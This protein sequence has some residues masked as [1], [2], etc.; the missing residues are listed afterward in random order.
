MEGRTD[1]LDYI[2]ENSTSVYRINGRKFLKE[3]VAT[4]IF[5]EDE[6]LMRMIRNV[7]GNG[8]S[9]K[10]KP[11]G[12]SF[13][14]D[15][16]H[17]EMKDGYNYFYG[18]LFN[19]NS[20]STFEANI[21]GFIGDDVA[22]S[23]NESVGLILVSAS[24]LPKDKLQ[25][26][27]NAILKEKS[28]FA[29]EN[30]IY[31]KESVFS[32]WN[33]NPLG[34]TTNLSGKIEGQKLLF[35][36]D[37]KFDSPLPKMKYNVEPKGLHL[38]NVFIP[39]VANFY[40][41]SMF[42]LRKEDLPDIK[43]LSINYYGSKFVTAPEFFI[44]PDIEAYVEFSGPL[45]LDSLY[46]RLDGTPVSGNQNMMKIDLFGE[47]YF[48]TKKDFNSL[49]ISKSKKAVKLI[50][51]KNAIVVSGAPEKLF[52][53]DGDSF[54]KRMISM[55]PVVSAAQQFTS[56][57]S[58]FE[59]KLNEEKERYEIEGHVKLKGGEYPMN[60]LFKFL[61]QSKLLE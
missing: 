3:S 28:N 13:E 27:A 35:S 50:P 45:A 21:R 58:N 19:L 24:N 14:S 46:S 2:P 26:Q 47:N 8:T 11:L 60:T 15:I 4:M 44:A 54:V 59:L 17:F 20:P 43:G 10:L 33:K 30:K 22:I 1:N 6:D 51:F 7:S 29:K 41:R 36:G 37:I 49:V 53:I 16:V 48:V 56:E 5:N 31:D 52:N 57:I 61:L 9:D 42:E 38:S 23:V 34:L 32:V 55:N 40:I 18:Y 25:E 12:I 39:K